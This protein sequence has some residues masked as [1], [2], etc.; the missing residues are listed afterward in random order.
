MQPYRPIACGFHDEL[1]ALATLR[2]MC[3]FFCQH[4]DGAMQTVASRIVDIYAAGGADFI[5]LQDDVIV[6][7]DH[8]IRVDGKAV[9]SLSPLAK[10]WLLRSSDSPVSHQH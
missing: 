9:H 7:A 3:Q 8:A 1:E 5:Q 10:C 4:G 6:R 2:Q